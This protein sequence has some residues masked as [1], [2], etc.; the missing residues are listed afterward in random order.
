MQAVSAA[1]TAALANSHRVAT[2]A[3]I[4]S[5][6]TATSGGSVL[7]TFNP[8]AGQVNADI[9][10]LTRRTCDVTLV[11]PTGAL[12]P[13]AATD[14]LTPFGN[15]LRLFRGITYPDLTT[16]L[17]PLGVFGIAAAEIMDAGQA[18]SVK[19]VG[20]DRADRVSRALLTDSYAIAAGTNAATAIQALIT[21]R[22][23]GLMF[24]F[25]LTAVTLPLTA[26]QTGDDPWAKATEIAKSIG[27]DLYFDA[28]GIC[29]LT[30]VTD[31]ASAPISATFAEGPTATVTNLA[32]SLTNRTTFSDVIVI[33]Q[34]SGVVVPVRAQVTDSNTGSPTYILGPYGDVVTVYNSPLITT[35][36]Q[37]LAA[38][39]AI[40]FRGTGLAEQLTITALVNPALDVGDTVQ[41]TRAASKINA[42]Y[43]LDT[44]S[45]PLAYSG[46]MTAVS[47]RRT[48]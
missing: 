40:L 2:S 11:D 41:V 39:Q 8:T 44:V 38:A 6:V 31:P 45:I 33:G 19:I 29:T 17:V 18:L 28:Y 36:A 24:N 15:E 47:R 4:W 7:A 3:Q 23:P 37:A 16:E 32:R 13:S 42:R 12:I 46:S 26:Y 22:V 43:T 34:G 14:I 48:S 5:G 20:Y 30:P 27:M 10:N 1:F 21:S 9:A 25:A 35:Q